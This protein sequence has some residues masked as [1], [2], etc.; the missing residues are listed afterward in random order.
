[1]FIDTAKNND[2]KLLNMSSLSSDVCMVGAQKCPPPPLPCSTPPHK[3]N[4]CKKFTTLQNYVFVIFQQITLKFGNF[5][6]LKALFAAAVNRFMSPGPCRKLLKETWKGVSILDGKFF[7]LNLAHICNVI[8]KIHQ[9]HLSQ[10]SQ[11]LS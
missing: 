2:V 11:L 5:T 7:P 10:H 8:S 4:V 6:S 3:T 1:M 9:H